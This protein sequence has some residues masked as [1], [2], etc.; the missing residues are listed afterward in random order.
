MPTIAT[1]AVQKKS[2]K[3]KPNSGFKQLPRIAYTMS[4]FPKLTE[5]FILNEM[6]VMEETGVKIELFPLLRERQNVHH[7]EVAKY[8]KRA[9]FYPFISLPIL[10]A[11]LYYLFRKPLAYIKVVW[12]VFTG[13]LGSFNFFFGALGIFPKSVRFAY[14][15]K[16]LDVDHVHA[17]FATHPAVAGLIIKRLEGIPFSFTAH[18]SDLHVERRMLDK[19]IQAAAASIT[20]SNFNKEVMV[21]EC[22]EEL[23]DDI[24]VIRCGVDVS[25]FKCQPKLSGEGPFQILC[26]ASYEEVKGHKYLVEACRLLAD[27]GMDF[28][29]HMVGYGPLRSQVEKQIADSGLSNKIK[30][31]GGLPRTEVLKMYEMADVFILPSVLTK[32]GKKEGIPV[33]IME[34]MSSCLPVVSSRLSGIPELVQDNSTGILVEPRDVKGLANALQRLH[35]HPELRVKMGKAGR[36]H[37][38]ENFDLKKNALKLLQLIVKASKR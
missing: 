35:D 30:I 15:M 37:I 17:H 1:E 33:V 6:M 12:E 18:G 8:M 36:E 21:K 14:E 31:Y 38:I 28:V 4:R 32:D 5:T 11:N 24:H 34:A 10:W 13:T 9:H 19:K 23:H 27:G 26:V 7:P 20:V 3:R 25:L 29:C 22:G 2:I 16:K